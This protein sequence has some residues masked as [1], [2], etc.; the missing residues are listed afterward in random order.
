MRSWH[1]VYLGSDRAALSAVAGMLGAVSPTYCVCVRACV[2][3]TRS[4]EPS[5]LLFPP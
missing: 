1:D 4:L 5:I 3:A 2:R